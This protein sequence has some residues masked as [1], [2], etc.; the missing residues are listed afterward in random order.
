MS[1]P[2]TT[3][4]IAA[5]YL[6]RCDQALIDGSVVDGRFETPDLDIELE[7]A[8]IAESLMS[9]DEA[10]EQIEIQEGQWAGVIVDLDSG[11]SI[12]ISAVRKV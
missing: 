5:E 1:T 4:Q 6:T 9:E 12:H 2:R 3:N 8:M 10:I 11:E 7:S